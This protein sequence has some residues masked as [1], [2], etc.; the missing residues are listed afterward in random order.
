MSTETRTIARAGSFC[1]NEECSDFGKV[2]AG[3]LIDFGHTKAGTQRRLCKTCRGTFTVTLGTIFYRRRTPQK[4]I[5][6]ALSQLAERGSIAAVARVKGVKEDTIS[7]WLRAAAEHWEELEEILLNDYHLS[8]AQIDALWTF[9]F[10]KGEK[11]G[12]PKKMNAAR[13]GAAP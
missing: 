9:V 11:G 6:E 5:V 10:H 1:P 7:A 12:A 4:D 2:D 3:N 8:R 13:S